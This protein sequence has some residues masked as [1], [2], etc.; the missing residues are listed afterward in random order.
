MPGSLLRTVAAALL[1]AALGGVEP[2][3]ACSMIG[4]SVFC[5][6]RRS[7][8]TVGRTVF[9]PQGPAARS[10]GKFVV[11]REGGLTRVIRGLPTNKAGHAPRSLNR[12]D[13]LTDPTKGRDFGT[14]EFPMGTAR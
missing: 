5:D 2:V 8:T 10:V 1:L 4:S 14:F 7:H 6:G 11:P 3:Q 13:R 9:F 12:P